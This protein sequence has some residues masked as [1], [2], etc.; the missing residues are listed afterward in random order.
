[1]ARRHFLGLA[2]LLCALVGPAAPAAAQSQAPTQVQVRSI[3]VREDDQFS[4]VVATFGHSQDP[5]AASYAATIEWGDGTASPGT[6]TCRTGCDG[7]S[8]PQFEVS[9]AHIWANPGDYVVR[10]TVKYAYAS[11]PASGQGTAR[12]LAREQQPQPEPQ[13][14]PVAPADPGPTRLPGPEG[15]PFTAVRGAPFTGVVAKV[16]PGTPVQLIVIDWGDGKKSPGT[17][18]PDGSITGSHTFSKSGFHQITTTVTNAAGS[19]VASATA[20]VTLADKE[21]ECVEKVAFARMTAVGACILKIEEGVWEIRGKN[22]VRI[23]GLDFEPLGT[24]KVRLVQKTA[25]IAATGAIV[26]RAGPIKIYQGKISLKANLE[27]PGGFNVAANAAVAGFPIEGSLAVR[28][29]ADTVAGEYG[30]TLDVHLGLPK[31][32]GGF[33][34]DV[35]LRLTNRDGLILDKLRLEASSIYLGALHVQN[36]FVDYRRIGNEWRGGAKLSLPSGVGLN[37]SPPPPEQGVTFRDGKLISIGATINFPNPGAVIASGVFLNSIG[38]QVGTGPTRFLGNAK[39]STGSAGGRTVAR[40]D[41]GMFIAFATPD[42]PFTAPVGIPAKDRT[43]TSTAFHVGGTVT[44]VDRFNLGGAYLLYVHP[45]YAELA[46]EFNYELLSGLVSAQARVGMAINTVKNQ[47]NGEVGARVCAAKVACVG[48]DMIISNVGI[49]ACARTWLVDVGGGYYWGGGGFFMWRSCDVGRVRVAVSPAQAAQ[50]G[51]A[52]SRFTLPSGLD[53]AVI[54]VKGRDRAPVA[55]LVSPSGKRYTVP[56]GDDWA[57]GPE[58]VAFRAD[59]NKESYFVVPRPE[60]GTW[61]VEAEPGSSPV[62]GVQFAETLP[63]PRVRARVS[64]RGR[65]RTVSYD[66]RAVEGQRVTLFEKGRETLV[67][68]GEARGTKGRLRFRSADGPAGGRQIVAQIDSFGAPRDRIVAGTYRAPGL[69]RPSRVNRLSATARGSRVCATWRRGR[70]AREYAVTFRLSDGRKQLVVTRRTRA[71]VG[72]V[73]GRVRGKVEVRGV[74]T[75]GTRGA[76][77]R[78]TVKPKPVR[79]R[80]R[81]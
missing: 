71:C 42:E 61:R 29:K 34:G 57:N 48:G 17:A 79:R 11:E 25:K 74:S 19:S 22:R 40:I 56:G 54:G 69:V 9:G 51:D 14:Q 41:A 43:F 60:A 77:A 67:R 44:L 37:A 1:M 36:L 64:G 50:A 68:I 49:G 23:N 65:T 81:V 31:L 58:L 7:G 5:T 27:L 59:E 47:F 46:G 32:F 28:F 20:K 75:R 39:F 16:P 63:E 53:K 45:G 26:V 80:A 8:P 73:V 55:T 2:L 18:A 15:V 76:A 78:K 10:V 12:V 30:A 66:V 6:V 33:T 21:G 35:A 4:G 38:F 70:N 72:R 62:T 3:E 24:A 13:P 52:G